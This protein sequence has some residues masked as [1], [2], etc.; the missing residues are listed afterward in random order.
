MRALFRD[1]GQ[2]EGETGG[3]GEANVVAAGQGEDDADAAGPGGD[4]GGEGGVRPPPVQH[5]G[6]VLGVQLNQEAAVHGPDVPVR[7]QADLVPEE[8]QAGQ[9]L[10]LL[11]LASR[12]LHSPKVSSVFG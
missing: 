3:G 7:R 11:G 5:D 2:E 12:R 6:G 8:R 9:R 1:H 10:P 4:A